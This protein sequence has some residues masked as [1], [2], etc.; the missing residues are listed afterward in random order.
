MSNSR[1][2][3]SDSFTPDT[4]TYS[5]DEIFLDITGSQHLFSGPENLTRAIKGSIR[6][7]LGIT[8]TAGIGPNVLIA[9]L[10]SDLANPDG[11]RWITDDMAPSVLE[12]LPVKKLWSIGSHMVKKLRT[13]GRAGKGAFSL[14]TKKAP[15]RRSSGLI[16][17]MVNRKY[18]ASLMPM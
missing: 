10:A 7:E 4:E 9:K 1:R 2:S 8:C 6:S 11:L 5:I 12:A 3:V 14:R 15:N 18:L 16:F 17:T 13:I